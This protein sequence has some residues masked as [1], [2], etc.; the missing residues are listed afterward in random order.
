MFHTSSFFYYIIIRF[1]HPY[2]VLWWV[3]H[4]P[5]VDYVQIAHVRQN[6]SELNYALTYSQF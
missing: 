4:S 1:G 3:G 6:L 2:G 5:G